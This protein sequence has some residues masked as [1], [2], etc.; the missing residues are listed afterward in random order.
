[1]AR[2]VEHPNRP[3]RRRRA[4]YRRPL[5][6]LLLT[7]WVVIPIAVLVGMF[8]ASQTIAPSP[9]S[10][11]LA[12]GIAALVTVLYFPLSKSVA[13]F[14][15][16]FCVPTFVFI[17]D[18]NVLFIGL[19][20]L[21]WMAQVALKREPRP[22]SSPIDW[23]I[24]IYM[25]THV[26][27][28]LSLETAYALNRSIQALIYFGA[29]AGLFLLLYNTVRTEAQLRRILNALLIVTA[30]VHLTAVLEYYFDG[31]Q[32][33]P[34]W[35]LYRGG[36]SVSRAERVGG[37]LGYHALL[38][39]FSAM[40]FLTQVMYAIR[41]NVKWHRAVFIASAILSVIV[42]TM[43]VNRGG[44]IVW[45]VGC[46][47]F[48]FLMRS[49]VNWLR[50]LVGVPVVL[51]LYLSWQFFIASGNLNQIRLFGRLAGTQIQRGVPDTRIAAW[52][53]ITARIPEHLWVGHGPFFQLGTIGTKAIIWPHSAYLFYL[54]TG[55]IFGL[56]AWLWILLKLLW[57]TFPGF[58]A[59]FRRWSL[60]EATRALVHVQILMFAV[61][62][63]R[64]SHQRGNV[65]LYVMWI[66]FALGAI[67]WKMTRERR[68]SGANPTVA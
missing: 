2:S 16:V 4:S 20:L 27:S 46:L 66:F 19:L 12:V 11:K 68:R 51:S 9:R 35:F 42:I 31:Y 29:G 53:D 21:N 52:T 15:Y 3:P 57:L 5:Q 39:D 55:G 23:A 60:A 18:T 8:I 43:T 56:T 50:V 37:V 47:Y 67:T 36:Q 7:P 13:A 61:A 41:T 63:I 28:F 40:M 22:R 1:M 10:V 48:T 44:A 25:G 6:E 59:D 38:A 54:Y 64:A 34:D 24:G 62:Q 26:L 30:F 49:R 58:R 65:Y 45:V 14:I 32:L 17:G 33:I